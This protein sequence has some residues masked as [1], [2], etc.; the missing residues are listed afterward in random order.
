MRA[1]VALPVAGS[2]ATRLVNMRDWNSNASAFPREI[3]ERLGP[4][5]RQIAINNK[6]RPGQPFSCD[7]SVRVL[8]GC[9]LKR[10]N[11]W[12]SRELKITTFVG[13]NLE[14]R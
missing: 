2:S 9:P 3:G 12:N 14:T 5:P 7:R 11:K 1:A 6:H 13:S 4:R 10:V 8:T